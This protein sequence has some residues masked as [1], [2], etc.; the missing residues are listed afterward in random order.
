MAAG[1]FFAFLDEVVAL[2]KMT[3]A[4]TSAIIGDDLALSAKQMHGAAPHREI[5]ILWA[6]A[7]GSLKN[8]TILA[9]VALGLSL[10]APAM[11][12][13]LLMVGGA[14]FC[15]EG[16][17]KLVHDLRSR[18]NHSTGAT[19]QDQISDTDLSESERIRKGIN[20][21]II[22]SAEVTA[23][24]L[25][26]VAAYPLLN[27]A[28]ALGLSA[29]LMT[30]LTYGSVMGI[31]KM[32]DVGL[33]FAEKEGSGLWRGAVRAAGRG[34]ASI[35]PG[36]MKTLNIAGTAAMFTVGGSLF[37]KGIPVV[38]QAIEL[39]AHSA[40]G[41]LALGPAGVNIA[42]WALEGAS[43]IIGGIAAL[44]I[45]HAAAPLIRPL[46]DTPGMNRL[47]NTYN[48][49]CDAGRSALQDL[50]RKFSP[51][52]QPETT[53]EPEQTQTPAP[54]IAPARLQPAKAAEIS[55]GNAF[56]RPASG[57]RQPA[58]TNTQPDETVRQQHAVSP[59]RTQKILC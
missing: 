31:V 23:I 51:S 55:A 26:L 5:P 3:M 19:S 28:G 14:Y 57:L 58:N 46:M 8:K 18:K 29:L 49:A 20:T 52:P 6:I 22:L 4:K 12:T 11:I 32:D 54:Q 7:K 43:G 25:G 50:R 9:P 34:L 59:Q 47:R 39:A 38:Q 15:Y 30:G 42:T 56:N 41:A 2:T 53:I 13:P 21:D 48:R 17:E 35:M 33:H 44:G 16:C 24:T 10:W 40:S 27:Q 37:L 1:G 36:F 45:A